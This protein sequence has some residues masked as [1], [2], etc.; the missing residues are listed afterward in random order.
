MK[1]YTY[2]GTKSFRPKLC[3]VK[4]TPGDVAPEPLRSVRKWWPPA[5]SCT[6]DRGPGRSGVVVINQLLLLFTDKTKTGTLKAS[7]MSKINIIYFVF[8]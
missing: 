1:I 6:A 2:I 3:F 5:P 4:S 7:T 8:H